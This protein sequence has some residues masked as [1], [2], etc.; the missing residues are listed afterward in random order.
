MPAFLGANSTDPRSR[1]HFPGPPGR[2][3]IYRVSP[4]HDLRTFHS[5]E[6]LREDPSRGVGD[7]VIPGCRI[8]SENI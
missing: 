8:P 6:E 1:L 3:F 4:A 2:L 5:L 7:S